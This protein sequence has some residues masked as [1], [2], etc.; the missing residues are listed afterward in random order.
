[1]IVWLASYPRSGNT[2][3]R[4]VLHYSLGRET[5][6]EG[7]GWPDLPSDGKAV[8]IASPDEFYAWASEAPEPVL[9][10]THLP[11]PDDQPAVYVVRDGRS[12]I[13]S[14]LRYERRVSPD[15]ESNSLLQL[16]AGDHYYGGW[17]E[18]YRRWHGR[19]GARILTLTYAELFRVG[20]DV[21]LVDAEGNSRIGGADYAI[22][23]VD[24]IDDP[25]HHRALFTAAY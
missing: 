22:A 21:L 9:V 11:P 4:Q 10:K 3:L 15:S 16:I 18:H 14:F 24:E 25:R 12:A 20:E 19:D 8:L 23:F 2:L 5:W 7:D 1:M 6:H 17:S 13:E